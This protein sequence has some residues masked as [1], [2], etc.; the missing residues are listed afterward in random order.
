MK[1]IIFCCSMLSS[2]SIFPMESSKLIIQNMS[3]KPVIISYRRV[4]P[5]HVQCKQQK[6]SLEEPI[7]TIS[8]PVTR[9]LHVRVAGYHDQKIYALEYLTPIVIRFREE[10][11][12]ITQGEQTL[13]V[14]E[15]KKDKL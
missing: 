8:L 11:I 1:Y 15:P 4:L 14:M 12:V 10:R 9:A 13:G 3:N 7:T 2:F 6:M 5:G